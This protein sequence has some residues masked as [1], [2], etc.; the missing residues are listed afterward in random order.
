MT[1]TATRRFLA[2]GVLLFAACS[3]P[4]HHASSASD[5]VSLNIETGIAATCRAAGVSNL[6]SNQAELMIDTDSKGTMQL[7]CEDGYGRLHTF[8]AVWKER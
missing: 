3:G 2:L 5:R 1:T 4:R 7:T 6:K 8:H